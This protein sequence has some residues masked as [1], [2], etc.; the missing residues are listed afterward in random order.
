MGKVFSKI[1]VLCNPNGNAFIFDFNDSANVLKKIAALFFYAG[2]LV[3]E[4][5]PSII[6]F[7]KKS[8][9]NGQLPIF[10]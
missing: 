6:L 10:L 9:G 1:P 3:P 7:S 8:F 4:N 2:A 5:A